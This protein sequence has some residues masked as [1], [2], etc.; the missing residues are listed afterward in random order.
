MKLLSGLRKAFDAAVPAKK[1]LITVAPGWPRSD[2]RTRTRTR[3]RTHT[4]THTH[5]HT[6]TRA[7]ARTHTH[8][9]FTVHNAHHTPVHVSN[10]TNHEL[11]SVP[12]RYPWDSSANGVVD[13]FDMMS[14]ANNLQDLT[15]RVTLFTETYKIPKTTLL[16]AVECEPHW[17]PGTTPGGAIGLM[18]HR[19]FLCL[20]ILTFIFFEHP[21][22][23]PPHTHTHT[24]TRTHT[25]HIRT[26]AHTHTRARARAP[27]IHAGENS[28]ADNVEKTTW[29]VTN[30]L[31]GMMSF[32]IDNDHGPWPV[33]PARCANV[34]S[35]TFPP[36]PIL[37]IQL[38]SMSPYIHLFSS[39]P[40]LVTSN[41]RQRLL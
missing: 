16:G 40:C 30:G 10:N 17:Q 18:S 22:P 13:A 28:D 24:R 23:P 33:S 11:F 26:R 4:R 3:T 12:N 31:Q 19:T 5:P 38:L 32:R 25:Y 34:C 36:L 20:A 27:Y 39:S 21:P 1:Y 15:S 41:V 37:P 6:H 14:Y 29:A 35:E 7:R 8:T 2:T 9:H